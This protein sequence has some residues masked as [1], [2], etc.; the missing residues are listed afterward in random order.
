MEEQKI[1][2]RPIHKLDFSESF[3]M[4]AEAQGFR[5]LSDI[6]NWPASVLLMHEGFTQHHYQ[7]LRDFLI[8]NNSLDLL[9]PEK[10]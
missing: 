4:M 10:L 7:E 3:K 1:T 9:K 6:L 8:K 5:I 2:L